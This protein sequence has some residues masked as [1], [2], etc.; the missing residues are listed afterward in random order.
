MY[1]GG[2]AAAS[3]SF[4]HRCPLLQRP[5]TPCHHC[6]CTTS[7][8][9][10]PIPA[11]IKEDPSF[12]PGLRRRMVRNLQPFCGKASFRSLSERGQKKKK[13]SIFY[14]INSAILRGFFVIG[15]CL[16]PQKTALVQS[17]LDSPNL[18][19]FLWKV[20]MANCGL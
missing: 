18:Y 13:K 16:F 20:P 11:R 5:T 7:L 17:P 15:C 2:F 1:C 4:W 19:E 8:P 10:V 14:N 9:P 6:L 3:P 12:S